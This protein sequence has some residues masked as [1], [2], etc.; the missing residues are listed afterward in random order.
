[1][2]RLRETARDPGA[3]T[4][5]SART[6]AF[7]AIAIASEDPAASES[8]LRDLVENWWR[9]KF[10]PAMMSG[11]VTISPSDNQAIFEFLH[12]ISDNLKI[13]LREDAPDWFRSLP[14]WQ[15]LAH[16]PAP[17]SGPENDYFIPAY[18]GTGPPDVTAAARSRIA[19]L[20]MVAYD[21][22]SQQAQFLQGWLMMDRFVLRSPLGSPY[23]FLWANPYL[24]GLSYHHMSSLFHDPE[25]GRLALRSTWDE[26][27]LWLGYAGKELQQFS[28]G[29]A[30]II[31]RDRPHEPFNVGLY[32]VVFGELTGPMKL[33]AGELQAVVLLGL[34]PSAEYTVR[35]GT[36]RP[37]AVKADPRG[38][39]VYR[40]PADTEVTLRVTRAAAG[41]TATR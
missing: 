28:N 9:R 8:A 19:G 18:A 26:D 4:P 38:T 3:G 11:R 24:P 23:E 16:Y 34:S 37:V 29:K 7:A 21:T 32:R 40:P 14:E 22:N 15:V 20:S 12:A 1:V 30:T 36:D 25:S 6:R 33:R 5:A 13:D 10:A 35:S 2:A 27:A 41:K 31:D 17:Y 39:I